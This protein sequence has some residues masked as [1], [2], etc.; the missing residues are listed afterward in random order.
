[1]SLTFLP[2]E[3][4]IALITDILT[5]ETKLLYLDK[6]ASGEQKSSYMDEQLSEDEIVNL[7]QSLHNGMT[8]RQA[9]AEIDEMMSEQ[10]DYTMKVLDLEPDEMIDVIPAPTSE[11][12]LVCAPSGLGKSTWAASYA[13]LW[14]AGHPDGEIFIFVR[15]KKDPAFANLDY[16]EV[17]VNKVDDLSFPLKDF[18]N[19]LVIFDDM[20]NLP[21]KEA[22]KA[23]HLLINDLI[24]NGRKLGIYTM[25]L[26]HTLMRGQE[27]KIINNEANKVVLFNGAGDRQNI[28]FLQEYAGM[29]L[30][31]ARSIAG[32]DSRWVCLQRSVPRYVVHEKGVILL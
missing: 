28:K 24:T 6:E 12:V 7:A 15:T 17:D 22:K 25:Y 11:R 20:D 23:I 3:C 30:N 18:T 13:K 9:I 26:S 32:I 2:T 19:S 1:M 27:T 21:T 16:N 14:L 10:G 4:P 31:E 8:I 29:H 5:D